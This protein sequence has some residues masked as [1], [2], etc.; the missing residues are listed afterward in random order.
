MENSN[1]KTVIVVTIAILAMMVCGLGGFIIYDKVFNREVPPVNNNT[2]QE[3]QSTNENSNVYK[4]ICEKEFTSD[5]STTKK[6]IIYKNG[7][8]V[9]IKLYDNNNNF[10]Y[11]KT[12]TDLYEN[13]NSNKNYES[14]CDEYSLDYIDIPSLDNE[15]EYA[16]INFTTMASSTY[17]IY[18]I[19]FNEYKELVDLAFTTAFEDLNTNQSVEKYRI[20]NNTVTVISY[21][22]ETKC[23]PMEEIYTFMD[24]SYTKSY[25]GNTSFKPVAGMMC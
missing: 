5:D 7:S 8:Y 16:M 13:L 23:I 9:Q 24:G 6:Y 1:I 3:S 14:Y 4:K 20:K 15:Y 12:F 22:K 2:N 17:K 19:K 18:S 11:E 21:N 25:T 10:I